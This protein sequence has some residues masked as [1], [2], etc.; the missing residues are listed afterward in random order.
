MQKIVLNKKVVFYK[1]GNKSITDKYLLLKTLA[2]NAFG[3]DVV[4]KK[5]NN[6]PYISNHEDLFCSVSDSQEIVFVAL[7][8]D[9][10][11]GIDV[12]YLRPR[13]RELLSY[14]CDENELSI[15]TKFYKKTTTQETVMWSLKESVQKSDETISNPNQY[16]I[17]TYVKGYITLK[18]ENSTWISNL[19]EDNGYIFSI[20]LKTN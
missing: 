12:E 1:I 7:C 5:K 3:L 14:C 9:F 6:K 10:N 8:K 2:K 20:S 18:K 17:V 13:K 16:K 4:I 19:F 15:L 11:I